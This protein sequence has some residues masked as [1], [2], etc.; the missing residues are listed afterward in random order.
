MRQKVGLGQYYRTDK[1]VLRTLT[2]TEKEYSQLEKEG[3]A[4]VFGVT[5]FHAYIY[6][7]SFALLQTTNP[8]K[9]S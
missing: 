1:P 7:R 2:N 9:A 5:H 8:Y 6:G 3:L 4:C